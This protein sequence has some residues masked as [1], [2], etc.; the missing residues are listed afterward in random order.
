M[1]T[2]KKYL[3][4]LV[5]FAGIGLGLVLMPQWT[6]DDAYISYRYGNHLAEFGELIWNPGDAPVEGFTGYTLPLLAAVIPAHLHEVCIDLVNYSS[7]LIIVLCL[8]WAARIL[9]LSIS[10]RH[11]LILLF[12]VNPLVYL[13]AH[14]GLETMIFTM[15][16]L[17]HVTALLA[18]FRAKKTGLHLV[19]LASSGILLG[20]TRPEGIGLAGLL[21]G[22]G[23]FHADSSSR[24]RLWLA[25]GPWLMAMLA[26]NFWRYHY[27]GDW[28]PNTFYAKQASGLSLESS[29][30]YF[31]FIA[32]FL[33]IPFVLGWM[34]H[35]LGSSAEQSRVEKLLQ[36]LCLGAFALLF[37]GYFRSQLF[38]NYGSRLFFP[39]LPLG[40]LFIV[41]L[42]DR[43]LQDAGQRQFKLFRS[44]LWVA[45][46]IYLSVMGVK[47]LSLRG[48]AMNY[49]AVM[50][51]EWKPVATFLQDELAPG[52]TIICYQ[53]AGWIPY[54]TD[55]RTI[56]FGRLNDHFL[57]HGQPNTGSAADYFFGHH[58][59]AVVM[60]SYKA[61][62][63]DYIEEALAIQADA[64][65]VRYE[66]HAVYDN[67]RG[68]PY[69]QWV[70]LLSE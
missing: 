7:L 46:L 48:W 49:R 35:L 22:L 36:N 18:F 66:L 21:L 54:A 42:G 45:G 1:G 26:F 11:I 34:G 41:V 12:A 53:D 30:A 70:Y 20:L 37:I 13:H 62:H 39:L 4:L 44:T 16:L 14:S 60:T 64:R 61:D 38:M 47:F 50:E 51:E 10:A 5:A 52:S 31:E 69:T 55:F 17:V 19:L 24:K 33:G 56:D 59:D 6:V 67:G 9:Q 27:F 2:A 43:P 28:L 68:Y 65:F 58:A 63:F 29:K 15:L 32:L 40:L 8:W 23:I 57:A 25:L 3:V